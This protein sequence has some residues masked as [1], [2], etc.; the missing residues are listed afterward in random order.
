MT[1]DITPTQPDLCDFMHIVNAL[2]DEKRS[3]LGAAIDLGASFTEVAAVLKTLGHT[4][5]SNEIDAHMMR[6]CSCPR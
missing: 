2:D 6:R 5:S 4:T 3:G 1:E